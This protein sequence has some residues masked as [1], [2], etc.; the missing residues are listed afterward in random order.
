MRFF[1]ATVCFLL[2]LNLFSNDN[3]KIFLPEVFVKN[4]NAKIKIYNNDTLKFSD[5]L[6]FNGEKKYL[7]ILPGEEK[8]VILKIDEGYIKISNSKGQF[9]LNKQIKLV[10]LWLSIVPP[11]IAIVLAL[12]FKEV[13]SAIFLGIFSG[14]FIISF[15][16]V[17]SSWLLA[18]LKGFLLV[19]DY[20]LEVLSD[21]EHISII[22][23]SMF[24]GGTVN[25][26][27][28]NGGMK[29]IIERL[30]RYANN[31]Q[32]G[33]LVTMLMGIIIFF[34]D[35]ANSLIVGKTMQPLIDKLKISREKL[36]YIVD[37]TAA[38]VVSIAFITTWIGAELS[39][40]QSG[41][42]V[43]NIEESPYLIFIHSLKYAFYPIF[44]LLFMF[45]LIKLGRDFGPMYFA[46]MRTAKK[47]FFKNNTLENTEKKNEKSSIW[48]AI[49]PVAVIIFGT[50]AGLFFTGYSSDVWD[51]NLSFWF[52]ISETIG[53]SNPFNALMWASLLSLIVAITMSIFKKVFTLT[54]V[55]EHTL[56]GF[57]SML[58]AIII[59]TLAW[60]LALITKKLHTADFF[61]SAFIYFSIPLFLIP[62]I[63]FIVSALISFSTG[64][65]WGT[66]AILYPIML[67][68]AWSVAQQY[69]IDY[70]TAFHIFY[71]VVAAIITGSVFGD[72]CSPIS[73]TTI[74][75]SMSSGCNH[76]EHV[77]TQ[78][79]YAI[80]VALVAL[81]FGIVPISL[82][83]PFWMMYIIGGTILFF[84]V[85]ILGKKL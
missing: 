61:T 9:F 67:P 52:K 28:K 4:T 82:G 27:T 42:D 34:D 26:I 47:S 12:L 79:P 43:L 65:S 3:L 15:Y 1:F 57:K 48:L 38:P 70:N 54:K 18:I 30:S 80:I 83:V 37:S 58:Q 10:P 51:K 76:I 84:I 75:S 45:F 60:A 6:V 5:F 64:S 32:S 53:N 68:V 21:R 36:S 33:Q 16:S 25:V 20:L 23:F 31:R 62:A 74:L 77:R 39:Y 72:H 56:D 50:I 63:T 71:G 40:I 17:G 8:E 35:Y 41:I 69:N 73:D 24:I 55:M 81:L 11:L 49:F 22:V 7:E 78:M 13:F 44:S 66:M 19:P 2:S 59:L 85:K 46:E 14:T 29:T